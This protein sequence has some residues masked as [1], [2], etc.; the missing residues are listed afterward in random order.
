MR[1]DEASSEHFTHLNSETRADERSAYWASAPRKA[2]RHSRAVTIVSFA[3]GLAACGHRDMPA[4]GVI[5]RTSEAVNP[6]SSSG[7]PSPIEA[8]LAEP[9]RIESPLAESPPIESLPLESP[10]DELAPADSFVAESPPVEA[11]LAGPPATASPEMTYSNGAP[12]L[13][14]APSSAVL[15]GTM[16]SFEPSAFDP[17]GDALTFSVVNAPAWATFDANTGSLSGTPGPAD[18]GRYD[19]IL[20]SATDGQHSTTLEAFAVEVVATAHGTITVSLAPPAE[21]EDGSELGE[22]A[23]YKIYWGTQEGSYSDSVLIDNPGVM[24]YTIDGLLP[25]TYY[26]VATTIDREGIESEFSAPAELTVN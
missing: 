23:G 6:V 8:A 13:E 17:D 4:R 12:S 19:Q 3:I 5:D 21:R 20:I 14:G 2:R 9:L 7:M 25:D 18:L 16:F 11:P 22:L 10:L 15:A 24:T 26:L 1:A